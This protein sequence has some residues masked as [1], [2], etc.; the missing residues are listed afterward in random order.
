MYNIV[1]DYTQQHPIKDE[2]LERQMIQKLKKCMAAYD[3]PPEQYQR[4]GI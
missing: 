1:N 4:L 2:K 3:A